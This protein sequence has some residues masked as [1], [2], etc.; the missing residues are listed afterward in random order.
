MKTK[1]I[2]SQG[3]SKTKYRVEEHC[4]NWPKQNEG[5]YLLHGIYKSYESAMKKVDE[6]IENGID[7]KRLYII[8]QATTTYHSIFS[9]EGY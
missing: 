1:F 5:S 2:G 7:L 3:S 8:Q 4:E 6:L 9:L